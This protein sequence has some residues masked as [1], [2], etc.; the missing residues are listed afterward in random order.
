MKKKRFYLQYTFPPS[1]V[2]ETGN[3]ADWSLAPSLPSEG[4]FLYTVCM[5]SLVAE[6]NGSSSMASVFGGPWR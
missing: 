2:G 6:S 5:E 4:D 1:C 3:L